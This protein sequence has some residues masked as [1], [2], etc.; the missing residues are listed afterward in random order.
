MERYANRISGWRAG[1]VGAI[2]AVGLLFGAGITHGIDQ[3][4]LEATLINTQTAIGALSTA[5]A[6]DW[7]KLIRPNP[8]PRQL[9]TRQPVVAE[10]GSNAPWILLRLDPPPKTQPA[11]RKSG[12]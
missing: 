7:A 3:R 1:V 8:P 11:E 2:G 4:Q 9:T 12:R 10:D 5:E 6:N